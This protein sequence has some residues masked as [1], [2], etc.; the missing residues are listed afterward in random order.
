MCPKKGQTNFELKIL[1]LISANQA[2]NLFG[3]DNPYFYRVKTSDLILTYK[4]VLCILKKT[5]KIIGSNNKYLNQ[6][7]I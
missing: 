1:D 4:Y 3:S 5:E 2:Q 7:R 6:D